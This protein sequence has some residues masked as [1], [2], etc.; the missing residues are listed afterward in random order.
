MTTDNN[1][2][3]AAQVNDL[4]RAE[5]DRRTLAYSSGPQGEIIVPFEHQDGRRLVVTFSTGATPQH[6]L[7][8]L[9]APAPPVERAHWA[10]LL[11]ALNNWNATTRG[12]KA[13]LHADDWIADDTATVFLE[14]WLP[15]PASGALDLGQ[16]GAVI[17]ATLGS[18]ALFV[19]PDL[20]A[21]MQS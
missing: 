4:V 20:L 15:V 9:G 10:A 5:L 17:D 8:T 19:L 1:T 16:L 12:P 2:D 11:F 3:W 7:T 13:H 6:G 18:C 14:S 21:D